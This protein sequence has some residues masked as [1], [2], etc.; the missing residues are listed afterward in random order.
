MKKLTTKYLMLGLL[1]GACTL[2]GEAK[3][4]K[5]VVGIMVD[6]LRTDILEQLRPYFGDKGFNRLISD[7]VYLQDVDFHNT[8]SDA[9]SGAA[10]VYTGAWPVTNG[11][12]GAY[13][14]D[15]NQKI[16]VPILTTD[17]AKSR[18]DYSPA[19]IRVS[20][21][22]DEFFINNGNLTKIYSVA[23]DPQVAVTAAGHAGSSAIYLDEFTGRWIAPAYYGVMPPVVANK[24]HTAPLSGRMTALQW[25]PLNPPEFY[26]MGKAWNQLDF[27][28]GFTPAS[29][30]TYTRFKN[31]APFNTEVTNVALDLLKTMPA[32]SA[33]STAGMLNVAYSLAPYEYD[34]DGDNRPE[35]ID[36]Y[37]RLDSDLGRLLDAIYKDYGQGNAVVFLSSTGYAA[38]PLIPDADAKLPTG[39]ITLKKAESLLNSYLSATFGNGDYVKLI[40]DGKLYLDTKQA[41]KKGI[42]IEKLRREAKTFLLRM[43]GVSQVFSIDEILN[44]GSMRAEELALGIDPKNVA[45]LYILFTPGWTVVDDSAYPTVIQKVRMSSPATPA[46]ILAP[47]VAPATITEAVDATVIAPTVSAQINIRAPNGASSKPLNLKQTK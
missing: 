12:A 23:G 15:I 36:S 13:V 1:S 26:P 44:S 27:N 8:V 3:T 4:P 47:D 6:Q 5:I 10:V 19:G 16:N 2:Y 39:E 31:S 41:E 46:F 24:N 22:A 20:T 18:H 32:P 9:P 21:I 34:S 7:G 40:K 42:D 45:D 43:T 29:R 25:K 33:G 14:L 37:M 35:L 38:E 11:M 30:D 17:K 28:Y